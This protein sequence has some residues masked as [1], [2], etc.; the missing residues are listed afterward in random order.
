V[1]A[2]V[3]FGFLDDARVEAAVEWAARTILDEEVDRWYASGTSG[4]AFR[5]GVNED[6]PCAWGAVKELRGLA[7]IPPDRRTPLAERAVEAGVEFLF[8]KDPREADYPM[9]WGN[10]EPS[11]LWFKPGFP[12]GYSADVLQV[13]EVLAELGHGC[14]PRLEPALAW[15]LDRQ[16]AN[17]RWPNRYAY[18]GKTTV[19]IERQGAPSRW[20]TLRAC[21]V[22][23]A[24]SG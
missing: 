3:H 12:S 18:R 5:C 20:V 23:A 8:S 10:T 7:A 24:A 14:D 22:L 13:L 15:L 21:T 16:D 9:G 11:K 17:G 4:P 6:L 1:R 2:L 19:E